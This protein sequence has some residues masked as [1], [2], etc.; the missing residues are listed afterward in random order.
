MYLHAS[1]LHVAGIEY[2]L[3]SAINSREVHVVQVGTTLT[4]YMYVS[5]KY[6]VMIVFPTLQRLGSSDIFHPARFLV[7]VH[8]FMCSVHSVYIEWCT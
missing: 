1:F 6:T 3:F 2:C 4:L 8:R 5:L 7:I